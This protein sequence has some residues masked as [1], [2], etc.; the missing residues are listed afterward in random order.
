MAYIGS[1]PGIRA[2]PVKSAT[3]KNVFSGDGT[4]TNFTI[5][6]NATAVDLDVFIENV[7]Q[8]PITAYTV[9][10]SIITFVSAP[11]TGTDNIYVINRGPVESVTSLTGGDGGGVTTGKAIAM[12]IV[13]G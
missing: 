6:A 3:T 4:T 5:T 9:T 13:F 12:S 2:V 10:N 1:T 8:E 7:R 11:V